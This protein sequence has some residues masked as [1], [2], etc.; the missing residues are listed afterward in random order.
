MRIERAALDADPAATARTLRDALEIPAAV[1]ARV[2]EI[3]ARVRAG[4]DEAVATLTRELDTGGADPGP[5]AV[6]R[7]ELTAALERADPALVSAL[8]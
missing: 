7:E 5:L 6:S 4:G 8:E 1:V 2:G 3:V